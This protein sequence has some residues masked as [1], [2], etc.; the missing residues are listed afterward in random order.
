[1]I[2]VA[3]ETPRPWDGRRALRFLASL[4]MLALAVTLHLP[5]QPAVAEPPAAVAA[6]SAVGDASAVAASSVAGDASVVADTE[7]GEAERPAT[8]DEPAAAGNNSTTTAQHLPAGEIPQG[9][10]SRAPPAA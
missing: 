9:A 3:P 4:A 5:A 10:P 8:P 6:S 2:A 1:V 7:S